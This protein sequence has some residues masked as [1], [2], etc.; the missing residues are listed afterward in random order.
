MN[1][2]KTECCNLHSVIADFYDNIYFFIVNKGI[3][4]EEAKDLTQEIMGK[5]IDAYRNNQQIHNLK[6]WL[7]Q[8]SR[9]VIADYYRRSNKNIESYDF[10]ES[11]Y[12]NSVEKGNSLS[13]EDFILPMINL[14]PE[15]YKTVLYKSD[16]EGMKQSEIAKHLG[17]GLSATKMRC[18]RA[19]QKL[20]EL[21]MECCDIKY[22]ESGKFA[23]CSIKLS[24][25]ELRVAEKKLKQ[26]D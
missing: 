11:T 14:L 23:S 20:Y 12:Y 5:L 9:N 19:R 8:V 10:R 25:H 15:K 7:F 16:I 1:T 21:F 22:T 18:Q 26:G 13:A 3:E 6:A 24:C 4:K 17:I 2:N